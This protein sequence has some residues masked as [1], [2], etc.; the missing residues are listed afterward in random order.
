MAEKTSMMAHSDI[1]LTVYSTMCV[2]ASFQE[3]P[4]VSVCI[5]SK[6]GWP[7]KYWVPMSSIGVWPTHSRFRTSG[8]GRIA[9]NQAELCEAIN[10]YL[11]N[12]GAD[13]DAQRRFLAQECTYLDGSSGRRTGRY[14]LSLLEN[15][16]GH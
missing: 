14:F 12:P 10:A 5:D 4:I 6:T 13:L 16:H 3:S 1:F 9:L 8:A 15:G 11:A 7:G 2:E